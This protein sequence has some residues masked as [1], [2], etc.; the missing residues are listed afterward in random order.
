MRWSVHLLPEL[1]LLYL[2]NAK[3]GSQTVK[4]SLWL[5][6]D[7]QQG[8]STYQGKVENRA[9]APFVKDVLGTLDRELLNRVAVFSV[10]RNPFVRALSA[11]SDKIAS[12]TKVR[13]E[14]ASRFGLRPDLRRGELGLVD[15]LKLISGEPDELLDPAFR[16]QY[17]NLLLPFSAPTFVG[18]LEDM[19]SVGAFLSTYGA[20]LS[21]SRPH[22]TGS[23]ERLLQSYTPEA[24]AL[25]QRKYADDF[26]LFGYS[27]DLAAADALHPVPPAE[28]SHDLLD[29]LA[30]G[31]PPLERLDPAPRAY[32][33][34]QTE[35]SAQEKTAIASAALAG[36]DNW[37]RLLAYAEFALQAQELELCREALGKFAAARTAHL[38]R[39]TTPGLFAEL[40]EAVV[41]S[42]L[43]NGEVGKPAL[44]EMVSAMRARLREDRERKRRPGMRKGSAASGE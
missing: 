5:A 6:S 36:E 10:V 35:V 32:F 27:M 18:R 21:V 30:D 4:L 33:R 2:D 31:S 26:R 43:G 24:I 23:R 42:R 17:L 13:A 25:V 15:F 3:A 34:F 39:V 28:V 11:Y 29:Y 20:E 7:R 12:K 9:S 37:A 38:D 14:F 40:P 16:P 44:R 19:E 8:V 22:S 1:G 41:G